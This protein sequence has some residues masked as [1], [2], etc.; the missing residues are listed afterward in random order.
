MLVS[1]RHISMKRLNYIYLLNCL[2]CFKLI[3]IDCVVW[4]CLIEDD[5]ENN[6]RNEPT[7][8]IFENWTSYLCGCFVSDPFPD[9]GKVY[10]IESV[11][12]FQLYIIE[13]I[14]SPLLHKSIY[15]Q[16]E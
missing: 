10:N 9:E 7:F 15:Y 8:R 1:L 16:N 2:H 13:C 12:N 3:I 5:E 6:E 4:V 14:Q 11:F